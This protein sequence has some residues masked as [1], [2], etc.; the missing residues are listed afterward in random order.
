MWR[1]SA[2]RAMI[3]PGPTPETTLKLEEEA[4]GLDEQIKA[5]EALNAAD[6]DVEVVTPAAPRIKP[7]MMKLFPNIILSCKRSTE[8]TQP[9]PTLT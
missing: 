2:Y 8:L 1:T 7:I 4:A 9:P 3:G 6:K 5:L